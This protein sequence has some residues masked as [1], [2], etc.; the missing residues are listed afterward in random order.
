MNSN[1]LET[2]KFKSERFWKQFPTRLILILDT[3]KMS[4][5]N[6]KIL[7]FGIYEKSSHPMVV[8]VKIIL[9]WLR[10]KGIKIR[11]LTDVYID[12]CIIG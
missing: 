12:R 6:F 3:T 1:T 5:D 11:L 10:M 2:D 9:C 7:E 8:V 4:I